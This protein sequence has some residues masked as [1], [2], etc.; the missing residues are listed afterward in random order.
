MQKL[1]EKMGSETGVR[2]LV[3]DF[4]DLMDTKPE[5]AQ[6]R[7]MHPEDLTESRDKLYKF[8]VG[9]SGGPPLYI[10][11]F[12]HPRLRAR[13]MPFPIDTAARDQWML[14]MDEALKQS[15]FDDDVIR[16]LHGKFMH[17]ADFMRNELPPS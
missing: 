3:D 10:N 4:Y 14:C 15:G 8:L 17:I 6:I 2:K 5:A 13:H 1:F 7:A 11:E 9:W 12:G 16:F